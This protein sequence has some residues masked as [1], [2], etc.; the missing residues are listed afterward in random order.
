MAA[1]EVGREMT[2]FTFGNEDLEHRL[3]RL[4]KALV[5]TSVFFFTWL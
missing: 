3:K 5:E 4:H 2:Y 1:A